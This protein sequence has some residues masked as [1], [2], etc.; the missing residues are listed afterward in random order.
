M[1]ATKSAT[2]AELLF[3]AHYRRKVLALLI[4]RPERHLHLREIARLTATQPGT[5]AKELQRLQEA[6]LLTRERVGN[7]VRFGANTA[8]PAFG[9]IAALLRKTVGVA[10]LLADAL[11]A[12][13]DRIEAAFVF[14]SVARGDEK[15]ESDVDVLVIGRCD[16]VSVAEAL[17]PVQPALG[18]EVNP[19]VFSPTEWHQRLSA[20]SPF[21]L[22]L[23]AEPKIFI[24]GTA[25]ELESLGQP[26]PDRATA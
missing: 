12:I 21:V 5:M 23:L 19:K 8:H 13:S 1:K 15:P 2:A 17:Y 26:G 7:Q 6:G 16:F 9:E 4:L 24:I 18:R 3:P 22:Q 14:G 20:R 11:A 10:D 25:D